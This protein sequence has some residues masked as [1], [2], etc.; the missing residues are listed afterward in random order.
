MAQQSDLDRR[1]ERHG[2]SSVPVVEGTGGASTRS[3]T[4]LPFPTA[5]RRH[6]RTLLQRLLLAGNAETS[7]PRPTGAAHPSQP[8]RPRWHPSTGI[9]H[10]DDVA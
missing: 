5:A 1:S 3:A 8:S 10:P 7:H 6:R 9:R 4:I 2:G